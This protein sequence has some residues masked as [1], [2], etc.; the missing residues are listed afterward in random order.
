MTARWTSFLTHWDFHVLIM[1]MVSAVG[2]SAAVGSQQ[3]PLRV[4]LWCFVGVMSI[5]E[6]MLVFGWVNEGGE[7]RRRAKYLI[8]NQV[9]VLLV[10]ACV[11][12]ARRLLFA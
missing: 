4:S 10:A 9:V 2:G 12:T 7:P 6:A 1:T 3:V 5:P 11:F 8:S